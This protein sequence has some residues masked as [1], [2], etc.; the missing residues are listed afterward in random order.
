M[1]NTELPE[2]ML[3]FLMEV[4]KLKTVNR[5]A[6]ICKGERFENSA[7]HSWHVAIAVWML[8]KY[9]NISVDTERVIKMAL[10]HDICEIDA[11]DTPIYSNHRDNKFRNESA[12]VDRIVGFAPDML[13]ELKSLWV[14]Y[15][16]NLTV[17][18]KWVKV[19]DRLLPFL[20]N[21]ASCGKTWRELGISRSQVLTVNKPISDTYPVLYKWVVD[22][23]DM[24]TRE[25][26]LRD[27]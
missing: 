16:A 22:Q 8:T 13:A 3:S 25:G 26:W 5:R 12:C 9:A 17:E 4:D 19:A 21:I 15:E 24:A 27:A 6:Y 23:V 18:S 10:A 2:D 20:H 14:E 7:E 1:K 11:G